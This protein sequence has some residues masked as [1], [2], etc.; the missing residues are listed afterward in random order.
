[1]SAGLLMPEAPFDAGS[2]PSLYWWSP[3]LGLRLHPAW[4]QEVTATI[5]GSVVD[6]TGQASSAR[7]HGERY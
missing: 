6:P 7:P 3:C 1:M 4:G 2:L 5:T